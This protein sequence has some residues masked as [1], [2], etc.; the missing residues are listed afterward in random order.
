MT[1]RP[2]MTCEEPQGVAEQGLERVHPLR[3]L[4]GAQLLGPSL[5]GL[6]IQQGLDDAVN[7]PV[8]EA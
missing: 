4:D 5:E 8:G 7:E 3:E 1:I 2:A 6:A